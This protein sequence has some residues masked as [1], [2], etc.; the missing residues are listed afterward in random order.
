MR[1]GWSD[2][3]PTGRG[4]QTRR[5]AA[6]GTSAADTCRPRRHVPRVTTVAGRRRWDGSV[7]AVDGGTGVD[8]R[9]QGRTL[10]LEDERVLERTGS[11]ALAA[12]AGVLVGE[13]VLVRITSS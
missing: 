9:S 1:P 7:D 6:D 10:W 8:G 11:W 3:A 12:E 13:P 2:A 4:E 5:P